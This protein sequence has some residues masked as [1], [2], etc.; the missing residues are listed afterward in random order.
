MNPIRELKERVVRLLRT[1]GAELSRGATLVRFQIQLWRF[2]GR[3]LKENNALAMSSALSFRTI[4]ALVPALVLSLLVLNSFQAFGERQMH[5]RAFLEW[6][7]L[8][9]IVIEQT[10]AEDE[11]SAVPSDETSRSE[12]TAEDVRQINLADWLEKTVSSVERKLTLGRIGPAGA[13]LLVW[14]ALTLLTTMERSLNRIFGA[15]RSRPLIRRL[16]LY[17]SVV[18]LGPILFSAAKYIGSI[19]TDIVMSISI[20]SGVLTAVGWAGP[21]IVGVL[22]LAMLYKLMPNTHVSFRASLG[23]AVLAVPLWLLAKWGFTFYVR[24]VVEAR[25]VYGALGLLPLFLF[26]MNVSWLIFLFGAELAHTAANLDLIQAVDRSRQILLAPPDML[27]ATVAIARRFASGKAPAPLGKISSQLNLPDDSVLQLLDRLLAAGIL[28]HAETANGSVFVLSRPPDSISVAEIMEIAEP[29]QAP[30][31][32][33]RYAQEIA[34]PVASAI[35][36]TTEAMK[37]W[38]LA[39]VIREE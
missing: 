33:N 29:A 2:C 13:I 11:T 17:W 19:V 30:P 3:R 22:L 6:S 23:A 32:S 25:S 15:T 31:K 36:R 24:H 37:G 14:T 7:G 26:W 9:E 10:S 4:F 16:L 27:A 20:L 39:D 18:T 34:Q 28:L 38:T 5:L 1:P 35:A 8:S 21:I 12:S